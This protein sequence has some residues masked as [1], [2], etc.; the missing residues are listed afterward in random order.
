[1]DASLMDTNKRRNEYI[2]NLLLLALHLVS[3][4]FNIEVSFNV[5]IEV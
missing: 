3:P 5:N 2:C 1:M 4:F